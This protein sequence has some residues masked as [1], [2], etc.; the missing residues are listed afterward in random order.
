MD[1]RQANEQF[2]LIERNETKTKL[3]EIPCALE[4]MYPSMYVSDF[5]IEILVVLFHFFEKASHS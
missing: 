5:L 2:L 3:N 1:T 4:C